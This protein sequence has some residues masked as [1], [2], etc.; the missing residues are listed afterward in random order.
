MIVCDDWLGEENLFP[1]GAEPTL[2]WTEAPDTVRPLH[3]NRRSDYLRCFVTRRSGEDVR[4][5]EEALPPGE[6]SARVRGSGASGEGADG[7]VQQAVCLHR[8]RRPA[9]GAARTRADG[10]GEARW[11]T[12]APML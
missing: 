3:V 7:G 10:G 2:R 8:P 12:L 11:E 4:G 5:E 6:V 9:R 1:D